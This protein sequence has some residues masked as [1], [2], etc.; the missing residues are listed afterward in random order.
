MTTIPSLKQLHL[1]LEKEVR[2]SKKLEADLV[3]NIYQVKRTT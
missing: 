1:E 3:S 2:Y